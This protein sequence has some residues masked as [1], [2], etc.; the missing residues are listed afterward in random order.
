MYREGGWRH[1]W[2]G[3]D[4]Y[5]KERHDKGMA[6][7]EELLDSILEEEEEKSSEKKKVPNI[8]ETLEVQYEEERAAL[9][10]L[11]GAQEDQMQ[12]ERKKQAAIAKLRRDQKLLQ[13]EDD[14]DSACLVFSIGQQAMS[15]HENSFTRERERQKQLA[16]DRLNALRK[17]EKGKHLEEDLEGLTEVLENEKL[18]NRIDTGV[19]QQLLGDMDERH[20]EEREVLAQ[21]LQAAS[22]DTPTQKS[23]KKHKIVQEL[24]KQLASLQQEHSKW[25]NKSRQAVL[26]EGQSTSRDTAKRRSEQFQL[27]KKALIYRLEVERR[28]A[29][30]TPSDDQLDVQILTDLQQKQTRDAHVTASLMTN[31]DED[32]L[33]KLVKMQGFAR[34]E[35]WYD[36]L[37]AVLFTVSDDQP[38]DPTEDSAEIPDISEIERQMEKEFDREKEEALEAGFIKPK[39]SLSALVEGQNVDTA[40]ILQQLEADQ[41]MR[42]Q[43]ILEQ[44]ARQRQ[45]M[46]QKLSARREASTNREFEAATAVQLLKMAENQSKAVNDKVHSEK[47]RQGSLLQE[48]LAARRR[49]RKRLASVE[50]EP[51]QDPAIMPSLVR[52]GSLKREKSTVG[53]EVSEDDRQAMTRQLVR[54][55]ENLKKKMVEEQERQ[56]QMVKH[57]LEQKRGKLKNEAA[58]L[59]SL[60]ERQKTILEKSQKD[61]RDRQLALMV[62]RKNRVLY[63]RTRTQRSATSPDSSGFENIVKNEG[64]NLTTDEKMELAAQQLQEKF[65]REAETHVGSGSV[66]LGEEARFEQLKAR[67]TSEERRRPNTVT[68]PCSYVDLMWRKRDHSDCDITCV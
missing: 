19:E 49:S 65:Q 1:G 61:E 44:H 29:Q 51:K 16:Q 11:L 48:K 43:A 36:N 26:S 24:K 40:A 17:R 54:Q 41:A 31:K 12:Q 3:G 32:V 5:E 47:D 20:R 2:R 34:R 23:A 13:K 8:L 22:T 25:L 58:E 66:L 57:R 4:N 60:G 35:G 21:L 9:L 30:D 59:Y 14:L 7:D 62:E 6:A 18:T 50:E 27:L 68:T 45:E 10:A 15:D 53:V 39:L 56:E 52:S 42:R 64:L 28:L 55:Q 46:E 38:V 67:E 63:E 37:T 33:E